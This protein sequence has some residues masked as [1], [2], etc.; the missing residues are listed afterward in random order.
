M[1]Y[2]Y[3]KLAH[4]L[5]RLERER[6][7]NAL[8]F[9]PE[10]DDEHN[11][12]DQLSRAGLEY[13][14]CIGET[15]NNIMIGIWPWAQELRKPGTRPWNLIRAG[16]LYDAGLQQAIRRQDI[17]LIEAMAS[18][19]ARV[20]EDLAKWM[21]DNKIVPDEPTHLTKRLKRPTK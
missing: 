1:S 3:M 4:E 5:V 9:T 7:V 12:S 6:Q 14:C 17:E 16:A 11:R 8:G 10:Y 21:A 15:D 13:W 2:E 20:I 18:R 19:Q